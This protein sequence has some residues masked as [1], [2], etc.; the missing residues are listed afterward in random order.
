MGCV[1]VC[2]TFVSIQGESTF[3]GLSCFFIRLSGCNLRCTYCDTSYAFEGGEN[4]QV[5]ALVRAAVDSGAAMAEV[6]GG[7]PLLQA[8]FP[9]LAMALK[10]AFH[11]PVAVETNGSIDL[12]CVPDGVVAVMDVKCPGSGAAGSLAPDNIERL[13][14]YDQL[15]FVLSDRRDYDWARAFLDRHP[16]AW[17]CEAVFFTPVYGRLP[18]STLA[19]WITEDRVNV[20]LQVP[21]HKVL[22]VK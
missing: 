15:K 11:G 10:R 20:R 13:R 17:R 6:T 4:R 22:G 18:A 12:G 21:L 7:E 9:E 2:E 8:S 16:A 14:P 19:S 5:S 1:T 3:A